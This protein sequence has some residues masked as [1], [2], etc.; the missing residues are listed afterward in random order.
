MPLGDRTGPMG[1]GPVTGR[2]LGYCMGFDSPGYAK[3]AA[4]GAGRGF[5]SGGGFGR[6]F[7]RGR[8]MR[9]GVFSGRGIGRGPHA[10]IPYYGAFPYFHYME[11]WTK[12]DE[13]KMLK[14]EAQALRRSQ[15]EIEKRL[16]ELEDEKSD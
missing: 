11:N 4:F 6:G 14:A 7:G 1:Q 12:E 2:A 9:P 10:N 13:I 16:K 15:N 8:G 3:R 5:Y